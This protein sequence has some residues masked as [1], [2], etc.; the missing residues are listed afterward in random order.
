MVKLRDIAGKAQEGEEYTSDLK[1]D[2]PVATLPD[3]WQYRV[4]ARTDRPGGSITRLNGMASLICNVCLSVAALV[5]RSVPEINLDAVKLSS[6]K[7]TLDLQL[8]FTIGFHATGSRVL[9]QYFTFQLVF[10]TIVACF[11]NLIRTEYS[12]TE[13]F[14]SAH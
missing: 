11:Y 8:S 13:Y 1:M 6:Q 10:S 12:V 2:T 7:S 4:S 5:S 9:R 3:T 14:Q